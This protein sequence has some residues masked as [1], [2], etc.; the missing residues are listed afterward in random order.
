MTEYLPAVPTLDASGL[1]MSTLSRSLATC[2]GRSSSAWTAASARAC[3][4][5]ASGTAS[6]E[7]AQVSASS[8]ATRASSSPTR[9]SQ[10]DSRDGVVGGFKEPEDGV[11][12]NVG[13]CS[14]G[15][16]WAHCGTARLA[17]E[18][19]LDKGASRMYPKTAAEPQRA[20]NAI[21]HESHPA[22]LRAWPPPTRIEWPPNRRW[23][24]G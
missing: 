12:V 14:T 4:C 19:V 11:G 20:S 22:L 8:A 5:L 21:V 3:H 2:S 7:R 15:P 9:G 16:G 13:R 18:D 23:P 6:G 10:E 17:M 24:S 1:T